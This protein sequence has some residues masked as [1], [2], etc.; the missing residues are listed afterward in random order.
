MFVWA[1]A[2]V[3]GVCLALAITALCRLVRSIKLFHRRKKI[4]AAGMLYDLP[5][6]TVCIPARNERHA[7][8]RCLENVLSSSYPKME[9]VVCDDSSM[10]GTSSLIK[11]FARDGVR[12]VEGSELKEGWLGKNNA[13]ADLL[14]ESSGTYVIFM[15]VDTIIK[16][17]TIGQLVAYAQAAKIGMVSVLPLRLNTFRTSVLFA[18]FRYFWKLIRH[19]SKRPIAASSLWM[20]DRRRFLSEIGS[21]EQFKS[22]P[23]PETA[24]ATHFA[25]QHSYRFLI[26]YDLLGV[27]YEKLLSS[28]VET[29]I[30]LRFPSLQNSYV[31]TFVSASIL[32]TMLAAPIFTLFTDSIFFRLL[33]AL[34]ISACYTTYY[35]YLRVVWTKGAA[36]GALLYPAIL[37]IDI[38]LLIVSALKY[39]LHTVT[40]KGREISR[41][42]I[43]R[44]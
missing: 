44:P 15:D 5:S 20:I 6:V 43:R 9:I 40:W 33:G 32:I 28:Q 4:S 36:F 38:W 17:D 11:S 27:S 7:M 21:F 12:F 10:D 2:I 29:G 14:R 41:L 34:V 19:T 18:P 22:D 16:P 25:T 23:E 8:T 26:S 42:P 24:I 13:L 31:K 37:A 39:S 3:N 35:V 30:R 1:V